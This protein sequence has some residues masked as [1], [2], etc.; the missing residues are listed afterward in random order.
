MP[1]PNVPMSVDELMI[2]RVKRAQEIRQMHDYDKELLM[3][4]DLEIYAYVAV[5]CIILTLIAMVIALA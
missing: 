5:F 2:A 3:D 4:A 1:R